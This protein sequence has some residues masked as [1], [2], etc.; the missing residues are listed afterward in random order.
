[1]SKVTITYNGTSPATV[2][3]VTGQ[4]SPVSVTYAGNQITTVSDGSTKTLNCSGKYMSGNIGCAGKTLLC[5]NKI[6]NGTVTVKCE[7]EITYLPVG[8]RIFYIHSDNGATYKFFDASYNEITTITVA[9]LANAKYYA[10]VSGTPSADKFYVY[11]STNG[12]ATNME[13]G[14]RGTNVGSSG[15]PPRI[16]SIGSGKT[17]TAKCLST[18]AC[19]TP[20]TS[21]NTTIWKYLRDSINANS[22]GGCN[23]WFIGSRA[24]QDQL[25]SSGLVNW[26]SSN[27]IWSSVEYAADRAYFWLYR[28]SF[29]YYFN[30]DNQNGVVPFRAF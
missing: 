23:D 18:S 12:L 1:M 20:Y 3:E 25:R 2:T 22:V 5:T 14:A 28:Y 13:W 19:F 26:Y 17:N 6:M 11:D 27:Y 7:S 29:W 16:N 4:T 30:K 15:N 10:I 24:E 21:G 8:G 9:G